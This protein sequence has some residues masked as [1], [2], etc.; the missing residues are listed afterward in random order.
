MKTFFVFTNVYRLT[1]KWVDNKF[2]SCNFNAFDKG[3]V[4]FMAVSFFLW[5]LDFIYLI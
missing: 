1:F 5:P 2:M 4:T 3:D